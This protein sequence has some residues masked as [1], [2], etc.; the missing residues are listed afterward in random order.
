MFHKLNSFLKIQIQEKIDF[1][2]IL[3][4]FLFYIKDNIPNYY[5]I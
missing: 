3:E 5:V 2:E 4:M 1:Y